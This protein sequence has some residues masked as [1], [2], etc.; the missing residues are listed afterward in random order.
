MTGTVFLFFAT[1]FELI[2][3][4]MYVNV[5]TIQ[6]SAIHDVMVLIPLHGAYLAV[7]YRIR[8]LLYVLT[9]SN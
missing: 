3:T 8:D 2:G 6:Y 7:R 4:I 5:C 1:N 9:D